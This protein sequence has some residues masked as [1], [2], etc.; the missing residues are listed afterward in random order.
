MAGLSA[1]QKRAYD[2][3]ARQGRE[4]TAL[5][6]QADYK[7]AVAG[8][9][10]AVA[11]LRKILG[12]QDRMTLRT[13][14]TLATDVRKAKSLDRA[15]PLGE[16]LVA[17]YRKLLGEEHPWFAAAA[18]EL[19]LVYQDKR[20]FEKT[21]ALLQEVLACNRKVWGEQ[22]T[23]VANCLVGLGGTYR[24]RYEFA[25]AEKCYQQAV[26]IRR[27]VQGPT[28]PAYWTARLGLALV[29]HDSGEAEKALREAEQIVAGRRQMKDGEDQRDFPKALNLL[30]VCHSS[31]GNYAQ[32]TE[33]LREVLKRERRFGTESQPYAN[34][35]YNIGHSCLMQGDL[36]QA[37]QILVQAAETYRK[38]NGEKTPYRADPL[39]ELVDIR[40]I[41]GQFNQA[42]ALL[43]EALKL[44]ED[45][46]GLES[47]E[48]ARPLVEL[49]QVHQHAGDFDQAIPRLLRARSLIEKAVGRDDR[50]LIS[51]VILL[52]RCYAVCAATTKRKNLCCAAW[53]SP[54]RRTVPRTSAMPK[55]LI[56]WPCTTRRAV[57]THVRSRSCWKPCRSWKRQPA[58]TVPFRSPSG[59]TWARSTSTWA[60]TPRPSR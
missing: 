16:E 33:V 25:K 37:E 19:A 55:A 28:S 56:N 32:A 51:V 34:Y 2:E 59:A 44:C 20:E 11:A 35:L 50:R 12:D 3:A 49:A 27:V 30:A 31:M 58:R 17:A 40:I 22:H 36:V 43:K 4:A 38:S 1:E 60:T 18:Y 7:R 9:E 21:E 6:A 46:Y 52:G 10:Q 42:E 41:E 8:R 47:L 24:L 45:A 29:Y 23:S 57:N 14:G 54:A 26:E 48:C 39:T 15:R 53:T 13:I 5:A